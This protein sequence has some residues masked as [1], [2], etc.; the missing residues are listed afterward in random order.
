M[1]LKS[2]KEMIE[3]NE[4]MN[5]KVFEYQKEYD[6][7]YRAYHNLSEK[8]KGYDKKVARKLYNVWLDF[9]QEF[10]NLD[11]QIKKDSKNENYITESVKIKFIAKGSREWEV[12]VDGFISGKISAISDG[13]RYEYWY[14]ERK[15]DY[16][17]YAMKLSTL[18]DSLKKLYKDGFISKDGKPNSYSKRIEQANKR[19]RKNDGF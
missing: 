18:E 19:R 13:D 16:E 15:T 2:F 14:D 5:E 3:V 4:G 10:V 7:M 11:Q 12:V 6:D 17:T 9:E 1:K 8:I